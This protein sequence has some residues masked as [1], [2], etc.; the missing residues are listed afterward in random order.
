MTIRGLRKHKR[1]LRLK[2]ERLTA[3]SHFDLISTS[4]LDNRRLG[5]RVIT[6]DDVGDRLM[7]CTRRRMS[8]LQSRKIGNG[9]FVYCAKVF[10]TRM[11]FPAMVFHICTTQFWLHIRTTARCT[12][13]DKA[14]DD[15]ML[16]RCSKDLDTAFIAIAMKPRH[17]PRTQIMKPIRNLRS[18]PL[19]TDM[20]QSS[21][22]SQKRRYRNLDWES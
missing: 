11:E 16:V 7:I 1:R 12:D 10:S 3:K 18:P 21:S 15:L 22:C 5:F 4:S 20:Q 14:G 9:Q 17:G 19:P 13:F 6:S 8:V 2:S